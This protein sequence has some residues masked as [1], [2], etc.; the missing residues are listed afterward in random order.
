MDRQQLGRH[1]EDIAASYLEGLGW[2]ITHRRWRCSLGEM[3]LIA[4]EPSRTPTTVFCEVKARSGVGYGQPVEAI[5]EDK[6]R[7]LRRL[8]GLWIRQ[9]QVRTPVRIDAIGVLVQRGESPVI[10]HIKGIL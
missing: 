8:A 10:T 4:V 2:E 5:T 3:D 1:G 6:V 9:N 7:R